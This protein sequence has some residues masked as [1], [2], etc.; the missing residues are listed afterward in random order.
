M[1]GAAQAFGGFGA[2]TQS[3]GAPDATRFDN[4]TFEVPSALPSASAW[5]LAGLA[6]LL[7]MGMA[8]MALATRPAPMRARARRK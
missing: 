6:G 1:E 2:T 3:G 7:A 8:G 5:A 4:L